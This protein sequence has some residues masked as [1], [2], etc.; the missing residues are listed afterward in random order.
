MKK[1]TKTIYTNA[2]L[3]YA[4]KSTDDADNQKNSIAYQ[5]AEILRFAERESLPVAQ[6]DIEGLCKDGVISER[7]TGFKEDEFFT[8][9]KNGII[10]L[11]I[12]R[13]KFFKLV[14]LL[15]QGQFKGVIFLCMDRASRNKTDNGILDKLRRRG[16]DLRYVQATYDNTSAG[17]LHRDIDQVF[18]GHYSRSIKEKVSGTTR[19]LRDEGVC[20]YGGAIG[21]LNTGNPRSKPFDPVRAPIVKQ[22]F[23][24][25]A[26]ATWSQIDLAKWAN[27]QGLT[28]PPKRRKKTQEEKDSEEDVI[29]EPIA[30]PITFQHISYILRNPFY[31]GLTLGNERKWVKSVS[32]EALISQELF[33]KVQQMLR[34]KRVSI[35]YVKKL[36]FAYRGLVRC[37]ECNRV[38][39][40][41]EQKGINYYGARCLQGCCNQKRSINDTFIK[42]ESG[43]IISLLQT[44][45]Q[46][47]AEIDRR[48]PSDASRWEEQQQK[49][50]EA[51][52][53]QARKIKEDLA[54]MDVNKLVLIKSGA[55]TPEQFVTEEAH[56]ENQLHEIEQTIEKQAT[57]PDFLKASKKYSELAKTYYY[58]Y[59]I[60]NSTE[61]A[62]MLRNIF[63]ELKVYENRLV[64]K[65]KTAFQAL[66]LP[67]FLTGAPVTRISELL[68]VYTSI[69][70]GITELER[71]LGP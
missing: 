35:H 54:Y 24:K 60:A 52:E 65:T 18:S 32:H 55:Y 67:F 47:L 23:E 41:Y 44:S 28:M 71:L 13:P 70:E 69:K 51:D 53:R 31:L 50:L 12:E 2:Y 5:R 43:D 62:Q 58:Q 59:E 25:Y 61:K 63:S 15:H 7:H 3:V 57:L 27:K 1:D 68:N 36:D 64:Y 21:Y 48:L 34:T 14:E 49:K 19:K 38:Y 37:K 66:E 16:I 30:R 9:G 10:Q 4:R 26:E 6:V 33:D 29:I 11:K 42:V 46:R 39:T 8:I 45:N 56:L 20:T 22:L 40:P 17:E